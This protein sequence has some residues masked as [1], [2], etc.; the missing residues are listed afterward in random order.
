MRNFKDTFE[1]GKL[2]FII[3]FSICMTVPLK[4]SEFKDTKRHQ[5]LKRE[6]EHNLKLNGRRVVKAQILAT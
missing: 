1:T 5:T 2:S 6:I 3:T 4:I